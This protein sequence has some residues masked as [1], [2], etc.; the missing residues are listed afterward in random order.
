MDRTC[1]PSFEYGKEYFFEMYQKQ[2]GKTYIEDFPNLIAMSK[3]RLSV[4]KSLL[5]KQTNRFSLTLA[6][7]TVLSLPPPAKRVFPHQ[8]L[9]LRKTLLIT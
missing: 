7:L 8:E 1:T 9:I 5:V 3:R 4:I 2:Y 6:A